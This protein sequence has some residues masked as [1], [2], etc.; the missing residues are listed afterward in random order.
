MGSLRSASVFQARRNLAGA[1]HVSHLG[2]GMYVHF[3]ICM[4]FFRLDMGLSQPGMDPLAHARTPFDI[5][6]VLMTGL[7]ESSQAL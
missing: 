1:Y 3:R 2:M 5:I 6:N 4:S 7:T